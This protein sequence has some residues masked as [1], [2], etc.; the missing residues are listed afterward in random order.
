MSKP[1]TTARLIQLLRS[2]NGEAV[3]ND[4]GAPGPF[5]EGL[6]R[7]AA[8]RLAELAQAGDALTPHRNDHG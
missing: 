3:D 2:V 6:C 8:D 5:L 4:G 1:R 7:E